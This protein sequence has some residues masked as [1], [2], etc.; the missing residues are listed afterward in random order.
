MIFVISVPYKA[1]TPLPHYVDS[2]L[3]RCCES[4]TFKYIWREQPNPTQPNRFIRCHFVL[5]FEGS[6]FVLPHHMN[7]KLPYDLDL[8]YLYSLL[9][10]FNTL[11]L[12]PPHDIHVP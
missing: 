9:S 7:S 12:P 3:L 5:I 8:V 4:G 6:G 11:T 10:Y 1:T 2:I